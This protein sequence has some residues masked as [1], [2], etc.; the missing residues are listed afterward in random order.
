[1]VEMNRVWQPA[2]ALRL[3]ALLAALEIACRA[4]IEQN[5][6]TLGDRMLDHRKIGAQPVNELDWIGRCRR[7]RPGAAFGRKIGLLPCRHAAIQNG[8]LLVS[9]NLEGPVNARGG[10]E[11]AC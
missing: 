1:M 2:G 7:R 6:V 11:I 10:T 8:E 5:L 4:C 3:R 9:R